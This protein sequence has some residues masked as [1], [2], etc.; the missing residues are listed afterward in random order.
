VV[1]PHIT[2]PSGGEVMWGEVM[3]HNLR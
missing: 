3:L 2:S 1:F